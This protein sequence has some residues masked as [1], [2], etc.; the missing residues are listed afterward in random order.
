MKVLLITVRRNRVFSL[1]TM[2]SQLPAREA[3]LAHA[4]RLVSLA[5]VWL[6]A[7]CFQFLMFECTESV[8]VQWD[9]RRAV[10]LLLQQRPWK[11]SLESA[12]FTRTTLLLLYLYKK[13]CEDIF[14]CIEN[15]LSKHLN[16]LLSWVHLSY[17]EDRS[18][19]NRIPMSVCIPLNLLRWH[20]QSYQH[21]Q[22]CKLRRAS[23]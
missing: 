4:N 14:W 22:A 15:W 11:W 16:I 17:H 5:D 20:R 6:A 12:V 2:P 8:H 7:L 23:A 1:R 21:L 3:D 13:N 19:Q 18:L 9:C 10:V